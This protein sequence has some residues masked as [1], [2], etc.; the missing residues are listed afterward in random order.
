MEKEVEALL[1][2]LDLLRHSLSHDP[3]HLSHLSQ[4]VCSFVSFYKKKAHEK[5]KR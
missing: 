2:T 5:Q 3:S 1:S 4:V